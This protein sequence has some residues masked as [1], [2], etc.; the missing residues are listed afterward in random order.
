MRRP[1]R[2]KPEWEGLPSI[3]AAP[4]PSLSPEV[5]KTC[6]DSGWPTLVCQ[7]AYRLLPWA[8]KLYGCDERWWR[9]HKGTQFAGEKWSSHGDAKG[10]N[11]KRTVAEEYNINLVRGCSANDKG[12]STD[13]D[14]IHYGDNS[15]YQ[16][17]NLAVLL[18]SP[19]IVLVGLNMSR[20]GGKA[21]FFGDHPEGLTDQ[22]TYEMW[23]PHFDRA[24]RDCPATIINAT[25]DSAI[26]SFPVMKL[27]DAL[28]NHHLY[29]NGTIAHREPSQD[30]EED[31]APAVRLQ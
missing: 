2:I 1:Q 18:G 30:S 29:W 27:E 15:G 4:G 21:H 23:V 14:H 25:P 24:A 9:T 20:P 31:G 11:D 19:Y 12:F 10:N 22:K 7:D 5:A 17:I 8:E 6:F 26:E 28:A 16:A 3:V 13:P